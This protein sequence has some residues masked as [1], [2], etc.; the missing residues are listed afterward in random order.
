MW[1]Q[2]VY[3]KKYCLWNVT[4]LGLIP[5]PSITT[6]VTSGNL[7]N[8]LS[9][10]FLIFKMGKYLPR[11]PLGDWHS[12]ASRY[13][14]Y[15]AHN[16]NGVHSKSFPSQQPVKPAE[17]WMEL[18]QS[19]WAFRTQYSPILRGVSCEKKHSLCLR[20][21]SLDLQENKGSAGTESVLAH[22]RSTSLVCE[23]GVGVCLNGTYLFWLAP[24]VIIS[25]V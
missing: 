24:V 20:V 12:P 21:G 10:S 19:L 1:E 4:D 5:A 22:L 9:V 8:S 3:W 16:K 15:L 14:G 25:A 17:A 2:A 6:R 23:F 7:P 18:G 13:V 11:K